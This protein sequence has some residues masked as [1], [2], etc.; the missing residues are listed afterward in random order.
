MA[1]TAD[2]VDFNNAPEIPDRRESLQ[3][4]VG[5]MEVQK[6]E[7]KAT[8][9][10][11]KSEEDGDDTT[12][13]TT[14]IT[15]P[16]ATP[17]QS[18]ARS[19]TASRKSK[20]AVFSV[21]KGNEFKILCPNGSQSDAQEVLDI[22]ISE[23]KLP[24][25]AE[26]AFALWMVSPS[27]QV[28]LKPHHLPFK[29]LKAW[30]DLLET[31]SNSD[32]DKEIPMMYFK[33]NEMF[34]LGKEKKVTDP[35]IT[36]LLF[37]EAVFSVIYGFYP[38][39]TDEA[40]HLAALALQIEMAALDDDANIKEEILDVQGC[41]LPTHLSKKM[42]KRKWQAAVIAQYT[43]LGN[44][45]ST[46]PEER[47]RGIG[48]CPFDRKDMDSV[49]NNQC[50]G[51]RHDMR[52]EY[53]SHVQ[54]WPWYAATFFYGYLEPPPK[55]MLFKER[56]D[57]LVR[58]GV[59]LDGIH[60]IRD[61]T[62]DVVM[63]LPYSQLQYNSY[64]DEDN[65]KSQGPSSSSFVIE[66]DIAKTNHLFPTEVMVKER[67]FLHSV[68]TNTKDSEGNETSKFQLVIW[69]PQATMMDTLVSKYVH[70]IDSQQVHLKER[71]NDWKRT[72]SVK[73]NHPSQAARIGG[74]WKAN[75]TLRPSLKKS[76]GI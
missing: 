59:N 25:G 37:D 60:V 24:Q 58:V 65:E 71:G 62:N 74:G 35:K 69:S 47:K 38:C 51:E 23:M 10:A 22:A 50:L 17:T 72:S 53:M 2:S 19:P 57:I 30:P 64:E 63:S 33:R 1:E 39:S 21:L 41:S 56:P 49:C 4:S 75:L 15:T 18:P 13:I 32:P 76:L 20:H 66:Y 54:T 44:I 9:D 14:P 61:D 6:A 28:Q 26:E 52:L 68:A 43:M 16:D 3:S 12:P 48:S 34:H 73:A 46:K 55:K 11:M 27:L 29:I 45:K 5:Y 70:E 31:F 8:Q 42:S 40:V 67:S 36:R 7:A